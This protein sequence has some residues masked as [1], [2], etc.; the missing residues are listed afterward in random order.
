MPETRRQNILMK[1]LDLSKIV[2]IF[3][4]I[5]IM[6]YNSKIDDYLKVL[7]DEEVND[8]PAISFSEYLKLIREEQTLEKTLNHFISS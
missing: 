6:L 8:F 7:T 5:S 1:N 3:P 2:V 4:H